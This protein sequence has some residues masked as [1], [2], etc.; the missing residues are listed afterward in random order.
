MKKTLHA[1][2]R[3]SLCFAQGLFRPYY[4]SQSRLVERW[5]ERWAFVDSGATYF[6]FHPKAISGFGI[7]YR[8]GQRQLIVV[9]DGSLIPVYFFTMPIRIGPIEFPAQMGF[10]ER[11]GVGFNILD[12]SFFLALDESS[13]RLIAGQA[14]CPRRCLHE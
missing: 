14:L 10:S 4:P 9:G 13:R 8:L 6:I 3:V 7:D 1:C 2:Y 11:L 5:Y 12:N